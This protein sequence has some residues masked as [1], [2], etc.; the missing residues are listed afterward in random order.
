LKKLHTETAKKVQKEID[1]LL[2]YV[3]EKSN[4]GRLNPVELYIRLEW[5]ENLEQ[6]TR[7]IDMAYE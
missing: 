1:E 2:G 7:F 4:R 5:V 3:Y 6:I